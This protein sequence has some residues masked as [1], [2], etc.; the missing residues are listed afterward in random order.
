[1]RKPVLNDDVMYP[2]IE[3]MLPNENRTANLAGLPVARLKNDPKDNNWM[4]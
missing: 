4:M 2:D 3:M 1:M